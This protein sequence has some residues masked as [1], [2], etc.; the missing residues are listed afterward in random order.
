LNHS[1]GIKHFVRGSIGRRAPWMLTLGLA[2]AACSDAETPA[3]PTGSA[4]STSSDA[5][6]SSGQPTSTEPTTDPTTDEPTTGQSSATDSATTGSVSATDATT[7]DATTTDASSSTGVTDPCGDAVVEAPEVCDDGV[8]DGAYGGCLAD[9]SALGPFCGD[10]EVNGPE[11]CDDGNDVDDDECTNACALAGCGDGIMQPGEACDDGN[12]VDT[13][14]CLATCV[15]ATC[16]DQVVQEGVEACDDG[17]DID[18]DACIAGCIAA[19]CGD[20]LVQAD[21]EACDDGVNDGAYGGCAVDCKAK[22]PFCGDALK[23]GAEECDDGNMVD[24]DACSNTCKLPIVVDVTFTTCGGLLENGPSQ[25]QCNLA[26]PPNHPLNGK[27]TVNAGI[28]SWTVP[29][30]GTYRIE[31]WGAEG[32]TQQNYGAGGKGAHVRGDVAL[33]KDDVIKVLVG[34]KGK[35]GTFYDIGGGGGSFVVKA[36]GNVALIVAGGGGA[37]G[38]C[39]AGNIP[40]QNGKGADGNG[41]GGGSG[42]NGGWCG[43]GGDGGGGGGFTTDGVSGGKSFLNGG[44]GADIERP[45]QCVDSGLGGFGG[46]GNGGNGGPGG[47]GYEGGL[48]G[49]SGNAGLAHGLGGKSYSVGAANKVQEDGI[50]TGDGQVKITKL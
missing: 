25:A 18:T 20:N 1:T 43:C 4:S 3:D 34:Q 2:L 5:L 26:Y 44:K 13:D 37:P 16:G 32:G 7:T 39:G 35:T 15:V 24:G 33:T 50:K 19:S 27:V 48:A 8:N 14:L 40:A 47:G 28:Q 38:N 9:C 42:N 29:A 31:A 41:N 23:N 17:N 10:T 6:T 45:G 46:G 49:G 21:V 11:G 22:A 36:A 12:L 30:T